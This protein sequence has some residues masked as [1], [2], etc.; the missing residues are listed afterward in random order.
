MGGLSMNS[1]QSEEQAIGQ[2]AL[3]SFPCRLR[4]KNSKL[5]QRTYPRVVYRGH[6]SLQ[7]YI[8]QQGLKT[9]NEQSA[10]SLQTALVE[11][12]WTT[13]MQTRFTLLCPR[14]S[15]RNFSFT[16]TFPHCSAPVTLTS[17]TLGRTNQRTNCPLRKTQGTKHNTH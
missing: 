9:I 4:S 16:E 17:L 12:V 1:Q 14:E 10:N 13:S 6:E 7:K 8:Q 5:M 3:W 11:C 2:A 15:G